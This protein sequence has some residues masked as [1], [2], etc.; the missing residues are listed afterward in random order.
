M[1]KRV[2]PFWPPAVCRA[3]AAE[4]SALCPTAFCQVKSGVDCI[5]SCSFLLDALSARVVSPLSRSKLGQ[6]AKTMPRAAL[7]TFPSLARRV[8]VHVRSHTNPQRKL[9]L[10]VCLVYEAI[11]AQSD[12]TSESPCHPIGSPNMPP[13]TEGA[14]QPAQPPSTEGAL[15]TSLGQRPRAASKPEPKGLKARSIAHRSR[16]ACRG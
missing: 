10:F 5:K 16:R 3:T 14:Y 6:C 2:E 8:S 13:S 15:H 11:S 7:A 1:T 9:G 4:A 12:G